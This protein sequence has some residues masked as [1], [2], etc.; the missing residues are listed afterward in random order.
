MPQSTSEP[1]RKRTRTGCQNCRRKKRKCDER[2]PTCGTCGR[3]NECCQWGQKLKFRDEH[4]QCIEEGHP[5]MNKWKKQRAREFRIVDETD[6][7]IHDY[8]LDADR[9]SLAG[10]D[11]DHTTNPSPRRSHA[12]ASNGPK[13]STAVDDGFLT[14][15][16][17]LDAP[18]MTALMPE[19]RSPT[20]ARQTESA[21]ANLIYLSQGGGRSDET[22]MQ[23]AV[24]DPYSS[25]TAVPVDVMAEFTGNMAAVF[26]P[27][28]S[29]E[30]GV[31]M[32][33]T[34]Y[35]ELHSTLRN[36][37]I[38]EVQSTVPTR[39]NTPAESSREQTA[40]VDEVTS[41]T[42]DPPVLDQHEE[43]HLWRN[44][45]DEIAPWLDKFDVE[46]H[47]QHIIPTMAA[48]HE[49]LR[50]SILAL[51][52][53][54]I[55]LKAKT[56][57]ADRS[58][59]LYQQ[60]IHL[61]LPHLPTRSTAVIASCVILCVLEMLS[62]SPK[63]WR[64]HLD[65]CASLMEAVGINGFVGGVEEALFWCF[66]RMD[67]CGGLISSV[68]TL[69]PASH[70]VGKSTLDSDVELF[71]SRN[72]FDNWANY[73][74]YLVAQV[75]DLLAPGPAAPLDLPNR[76]DPVFRARWLKLWRHITDWHELRPAPLHSIM[77][78]PSSDE[79]PFPTILFSNPAAISG[80]QLYHTASILMLQ[81]QPHGLRLTS[82]KPR[83]ILW[84]ARQIC[85]IS[86]SN[87]HHGAWTNGVQPLWIAGRC[88]SH[89]AEHKAILKLLE[90]IER[91]SGWGTRWRAEDLKEFWGDLGD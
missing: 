74:V 72:H 76:A 25:L 50:Y 21:V 84:H 43:M 68:K 30:D 35:H 3:R 7:V 54:Q 5:S 59:A 60:A 79:S 17:F 88:M 9:G 18:A 78:I 8:Q 26:T 23:S 71:R 36:H 24:P 22:E 42:S 77:T 64:R 13:I 49:H 16:G 1:S 38:Q 27:E 53:R 2:R 33:G 48:S 62:C 89:H 85:G 4:A 75:L 52:A 6:Q 73:S 32:P 47:F 11:D 81:N 56:R 45:F 46:R 51:S 44:W 61:L 19:Q 14:S 39:P 80:N 58:L 83:S 66:A 57:P 20:S 63:A 91:E 65:G 12:A 37:L 28:G 67:V 90:K 55:E 40:A 86:I 87:D 41:D 70:W 82:P 29:L 34:A 15:L 69:I 10:E 31:F